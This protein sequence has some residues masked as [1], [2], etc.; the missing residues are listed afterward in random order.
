[1]VRAVRFAHFGRAALW[2]K[3]CAALRAAHSLHGVGGAALGGGNFV[4]M[5]IVWHSL[6]TPLGFF[7]RQLWLISGN[8]KQLNGINGH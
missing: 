5:H 8:E 6:G 4:T 7:A 3:L 1:M 2:V